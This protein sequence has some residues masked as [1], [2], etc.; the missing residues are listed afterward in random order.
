MAVTDLHNLF[1]I[2][3]IIAAGGVVLMVLARIIPSVVSVRFLHVLYKLQLP[4][5]ALVAT[6]ASLG[7]LY[8][9][10]YGNHWLPCRFCWFQR[11]FMYS[12][13][14]ILI[15]A[16]IRRDRGVRWYAVALATIGLLVSTWHNLLERGVVTESKACAASVPCAN[17]YFVSFG[18]FDANARPAGFPSITLAVMAFCGFAAILALLLLPEPLEAESPEDGENGEPKAG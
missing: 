6:T 15:L 1:A 17:P 10:E 14:V 3:A 18:H 12:L 8:M 13:A 5:A 11:I 9:S 2:L 4:L 7:S 16:T